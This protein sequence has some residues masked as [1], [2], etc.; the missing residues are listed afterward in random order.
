MHKRLIV[1]ALA[2]TALVVITGSALAA[3]SQSAV[4]FDSSVK[5]GPKANVPSYGPEAYSTAQVGGEA[6]LAGSKRKLTSAIV[7][8]S[9]WAC[10]QGHW[11]SNTANPCVTP[12][13]AKYSLPV[14]LNIY[15]TAGHLLTSKTQT[16]DIS[17]R[18]SANPTKCLDGRWY[19]TTDKKCF[20]GLAQDAT[21]TFDGATTLPNTIR[22]AITYDTSHYG[23]NPKGDQACTSATAGCFYD[24]L[25]VALTDA[26]PSVGTGTGTLFFDAAGTWSNVDAVDTPAVQFKAGS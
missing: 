3:A 9:S 12:T 24:S 1:A 10:V 26:A 5:T 22:Y 15:D 21:F 25:N 7:T 18:P 13:G 4:I 17:Y 16:F 11:G 8:L 2:A 19:S 6:T 20:N 14:T 23:S